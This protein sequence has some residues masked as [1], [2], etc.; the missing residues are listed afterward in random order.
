[1]SR[2]GPKFDLK[3]WAK[4][5]IEVYLEVSVELMPIIILTKHIVTKSV[6]YR[7]PNGYLRDTSF[8]ALFSLTQMLTQMKILALHHHQL[9]HA[10]P[11]NPLAL[12]RILAD[13]RTSHLDERKKMMQLWANYLDGLKV[14]AK[15]IPL[16]RAS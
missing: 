1:M 11:I 12:S 13:N 14:G 3:E 2:H 7:V 8:V 4:Q 9:F 16:K 15:V 10:I 6:R 5:L